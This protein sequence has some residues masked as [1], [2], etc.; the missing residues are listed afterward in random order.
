MRWDAIGRGVTPR[1][2]SLLA[3]ALAPWPAAAQGFPA[4]PLRIIVPF[5]PG[6]SGDITARLVG[7]YI[8][9]TTGQAVVVDNRPGANGVIGTMAVKQAAPDGYTLLLATTSTH[10]ANPS[11]V[12]DLPYDP[13]RDFTRSASSGR[14]G[15]TCWCGRTP[16]A[17]RGGAGGGGQGEA[18]RRLLRPFQRVVARAGRAAERHGRDAA[19]GRAVPH[20]RR[21]LRRPAGRPARPHLRRYHRGRRVPAAG[22]GAR[23]G[24]HPPGPLGPLARPAGAERDLAG[25]RADGLP[26][27][28]RPG[29]HAARGGAAG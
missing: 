27:H 24:D 21:R 15:P 12:R 28:R 9:E 11:T 5:A 22:P 19:A 2:R 26:R 10:S 6:G 18:G 20:H 16:L 3:A 25:F 14:T 29:R 13:E 17:R 1:R 4:R 23:A 7:K 8:E